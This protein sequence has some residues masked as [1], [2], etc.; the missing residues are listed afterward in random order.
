M[1]YLKTDVIVIKFNYMCVLSLLST[2]TVP[3][4]SSICYG[5]KNGD[6]QTCHTREVIARPQTCAAQV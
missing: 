2:F 5:S 6:F 1:V 3:V 4:T